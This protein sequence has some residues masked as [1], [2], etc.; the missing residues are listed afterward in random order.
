[1]ETGIRFDAEGTFGRVVPFK[2]LPGADVYHSL[3][4]LCEK[5]KIQGGVILAAFGSLGEAH[6]KN[7]ITI[8]G[9][10][11]GA[12]YGDEEVYSFPMELTA[13]NGLICTREDGV[14]EP[15]IHISLS[16]RDGFAAGG[17]LCPGTKVLITIEGAI[18]EFK[19]VEMK[20]ELDADRGI[21]T[22]RPIT[23]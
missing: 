1:M 16:G 17:H 14:I 22:F 2:L 19:G 15:H 23:L 11:Y 8:P 21:Y 18:G 5:H 10:K 20:K 12:G 7:P 4:E 6:I 13:A 9:A 3:V